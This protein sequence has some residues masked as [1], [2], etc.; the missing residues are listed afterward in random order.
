MNDIWHFLREFENKDLVKHYI[1]TKFG[2][3]INTSKATEITSAF[4]QGRSYFDSVLNSD[5][6]VKPL[7]QY[8]GIVA[9]SRGLILILNRKSREN[10][11]FPSHGLKISNWSDISPTGKFENIVVKTSSGTFKELVKATNNKSYFR[12][13]SNYINWHLEY[14]ILDEAYEFSL[15]ELSYSYP[16]L[17]KSVEA[18]LGE[19]IP[20]YQLETLKY[21]EGKTIINAIGKGNFERIFPEQLYKN[22]TIEESEKITKVTFK[23]NIYPHISQKWSSSFQV[24]G[25]PYLIPPFNSTLFLNEIS[26]MFATSFIFGTISRYYPTAWNNITSGVK[27]DR[28]LPFAI[29]LMDFLQEKYPQIVMDFINSPY[30]FENNASH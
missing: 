20:S 13:K 4:K 15:K 10:N 3:E 9:L 29:N 28:I 17:K 19:S 5:I 23:S 21:A 11:I 1:K 6:S 8:Y 7:L 25:D 26:K 12:A 27:D 2:Y 16:D 18:W 24:I 30:N 14:V 22:R